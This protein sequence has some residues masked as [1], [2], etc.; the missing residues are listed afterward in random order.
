MTVFAIM[1]KKPE[2]PAPSGG[3]TAVFGGGNATAFVPIDF[4]DYFTISTTGNA[5]IFGDLI[6]ARIYP[7]G[8]SNGGSHR[9]IFGKW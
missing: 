5:S 9:G 8:C 7:F 3:D 2:D 6:T 4:M 1:I